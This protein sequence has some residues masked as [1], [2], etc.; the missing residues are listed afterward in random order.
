[1]PILPAFL[2]AFLLA[3]LAA[4][5]A[6]CGGG[7][8]SKT[9]VHTRLI[10]EEPDEVFKIAGIESS[11]EIFR[12]TFERPEDL[13]PWTVS[14]ADQS[15]AMDS[16]A[17]VIRSSEPY[18]RM[19]RTTRLEAAEVD[20]LEIRVAGLKRGEMRFF[21]GGP[22]EKLQRARMIRRQ[23][24]E[25][26]PGESNVYTLDL[27]AEP[28][29]SGRITKMRLDPT[30]LAG[31]EVRI[32]SIRGLKRHF[33]SE[34]L[35]R[36]LSRP[37]KIDLGHDVRNGLL[38]PP[39]VEIEREVDVPKAARLRLAWASDRSQRQ[40][41]DF[42]VSVREGG[43][44]AVL[45]TTTSAEDGGWHDAEVDLSAWAGRRVRLGFATR[46]AA[47]FDP[48]RGFPYWG[49]PV[50]FAPS[51]AKPPPNMVLI[52]VDTLR[53]DRLSLYGYERATT[54]EIDA[55]ARRRAVTFKNAVAAAPWTLP[56]HI[57]IFSGLDALS[58][59]LNHDF[60][61]PSSLTTLAEHLQT[62]GYR[63]EAVTGGVYL[64]PRY[65][66][67]QGFDR[68][69]YWP[70]ARDQK[71]ELERG[72]Q[73]VLEWL[74]GGSVQPFFLLLHTYEVHDPFHPREPFLSLLRDGPPIEL[75]GKVVTPRQEPSEDNGFVVRKQFALRQGREFS[76]LDAEQLAY[77][78]DLYDSGVAFA[79]ALLGRLLR[80][81]EELSLADDTMVVLTSDHG[82]VLGEHN[83]A[84]HA[85]LWDPNLLVPLI[86]ALPGAPADDPA[87][88]SSNGRAPAFVDR[89]VRSVDILPTVLDAVGL[90]IPP[91]LD[92]RSL[93]PL[94]ADP[95]ADFPAEAWSYASSTNH[96]ISLRVS[97][98]LKYTFN[99]SLWRAVHGGEELYRLSE[100][101]GEELDLASRDGETAQR[102]YRSLGERFEDGFK[103]LRLRFA[104]GD[105]ALYRVE[106]DSS[107]GSLRP[108]RVKVLGLPAEAAASWSQ[109]RLI[110]DVPTASDFTVF[111]EA[112]DAR[113]TL[114]AVVK[115]ADGSKL[116]RRSWQVADLESE[117]HLAVPQGPDGR[118]REVKRP[119][120][121]G[122]AGIRLHLIQP[123][124]YRAAEEAID[125]ELEQKLR[126]LGYAD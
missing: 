55:W 25:H 46:S 85:Y 113:G 104:N 17:L 48:T 79:D 11:R 28:A 77:V 75:P 119:L 10:A 50:I 19:I 51:A 22:K 26:D 76:P 90:A 121:A 110:V 67:S 30:S 91:G 63:T 3:A 99:N 24:R 44:S 95:G 120:E 82:E 71:E 42:E 43:E 40:P 112:V 97:N 62:A 83:L 114:E 34:L 54:P 49:D 105:R 80:R 66:F 35:A 98:R 87:A 20:T 100:D 108:N 122:T 41:V 59:G 74:D 109:Q 93:L 88:G 72:I 21:W 117:I 96:G 36:A 102:L 1:M 52:I 92:G 33:D 68:F 89:Q 6:A 65:G 111:V 29:W 115:R 103:G 56:S 47:D 124:A 14:R 123:I 39:A 60:P 73:E 18:P 57:S 61:L 45:F 23:A 8:G 7:G 32:E 86:V 84:S 9:A 125:P 16:G 118:C 53:A 64:H 106:L 27:I 58:H 4:L 2:P 116:C 13:E 101:P 94:I 31:Q 126:A 107:R 78:N 38:A 12:W 69:R 5:L 81:L 70:S 37:W 15:L